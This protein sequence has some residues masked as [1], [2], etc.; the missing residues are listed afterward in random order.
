MALLSLY[1]RLARAVLYLS[2]TQRE[3]GLKERVQVY[4]KLYRVSLLGI[5]FTL[6]YTIPP[7]PQFPLRKRNSQM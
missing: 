1:D 5:P 7:C 3:K 2:P 4:A 6:S